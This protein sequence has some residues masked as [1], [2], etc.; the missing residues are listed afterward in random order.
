M[1]RIILAHLPAQRIERLYSGTNLRPVTDRTAVT[2]VQLQTQ[3]AADRKA[4]LAWSDGNFEAGISSVAAAIF[5]VTNAPVAALNVTGRSSDFSG[6]ARRNQIGEAVK[7]A[8]LEISQ[9]LG[10]LDTG[11]NAEKPIT[12]GKTARPRRQPTRVA[13]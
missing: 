12:D 10:W 8:A 7:A 3:L 13:S 4:G 1:G 5:D 9:R 2:L 6:T 11:T